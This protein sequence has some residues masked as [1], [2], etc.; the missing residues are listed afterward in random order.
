MYDMQQEDRS[1]VTMTYSSPLTGDP[2]GL[3]FMQPK[4]KKDLAA[5]REMMLSWA[6][7]HNGFLGGSGCSG[8]EISP[9]F[10]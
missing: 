1:K 4:T 2:V 9:I 7:L 10:L 3:S 5:R 6:Y 8:R